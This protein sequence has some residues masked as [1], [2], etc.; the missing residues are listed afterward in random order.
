MERLIKIETTEKVQRICELATYSPYEVW[1]SVDGENL[2]AR[3]I[4]GLFSL[5]GKEAYVVVEDDVDRDSF[6]KL[7]NQ[8]EAK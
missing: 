7:M 2:D 1:L 3:S 5:V 8:I 6:N 4:L